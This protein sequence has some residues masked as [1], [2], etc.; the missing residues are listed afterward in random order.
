MIL[1]KTKQKTEVT[2]KT[3]MW[4]VIGNS[5]PNPCE[6]AGT[7]TVVCAVKVLAGVCADDI[8]SSA[9]GIDTEVKASSLA[10]LVS[11]FSFTLLGPFEESFRCC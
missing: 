7:F 3:L 11:T 4:T 9:P 10:A 1:I 2:R 5:C 6:V 8:I